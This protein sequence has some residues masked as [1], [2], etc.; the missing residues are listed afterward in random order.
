MSHVNISIHAVWGTK[1]RYPFLTN[2]LK[3]KVIKH[4]Q[5]NAKIKNLYIDSIDG[6]VDHL[7]CLFKLNSDM[8]VSKAMQ[9]IKGE[10]SHWI[11]K[12]KLTKSTFEWAV[13]YYAVSVSK[14]QLDRVRNYIRNQEEHHKRITFED[15]YQKF[16]LAFNI[17]RKFDSF[18]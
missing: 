3:H 9:L 5:E 2:D 8:S 15:E 7:H 12:E 17:E 13:D 14:S 4:I 6:D 11:N 10:S 1:F 18:G 16:L